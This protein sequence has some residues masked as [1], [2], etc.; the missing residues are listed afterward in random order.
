MVDYDKF[1]PGTECPDCGQE[2]A[3]P[4][5][6]HWEHDPVPHVEA[7]DCIRHLRKQLDRALAALESHNLL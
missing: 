5:G 4:E 6:G 1:K 2:I 3:Q 7:R